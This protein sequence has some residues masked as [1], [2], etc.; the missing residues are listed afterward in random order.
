MSRL[1]AFTAL[2]VATTACTSAPKVDV[3]D[4]LRP[5]AGEV[6]ALTTPARGVQI[7]ECRGRKDGA[8]F[9]WSFVAPE[10]ELFDAKSRSVGHHGAGPTWQA[11][12]G[13]R[14]VGSLKARADAPVTGAIPWLLLSAKSTGSAGALAGVTSVQRINTA[15]GVAPATPC[16]DDL[17][18]TTVRVPYSADYVFY[19][20]R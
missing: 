20:A 1:Q 10:A 9:E 14:I 16:T 6:V 13:S 11:S 4:S 5:A 18:G 2:A 3:P 19:T 12:D 7:Y 8:G 17:K 15:G